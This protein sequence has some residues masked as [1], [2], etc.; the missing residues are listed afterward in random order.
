[1]DR[2]ETEAARDELLEDNEDDLEYHI[3]FP[4]PAQIETT[5]GESKEF[6]F[7]DGGRSGFADTEPVVFLLGWM[8]C[9]DKHLAKY[10]KIYE[11]AG[12]VTIRYTA[13]DEYILFH[14]DKIRPLAKKLL[15]LVEEMSLENSP[16]FC[17]AFSNGGCSVYQYMVES[18]HNCPE[19][20]SVRRNFR[21]QVFD[22]GPGRARVGSLVRAMAEVVPGGFSDYYVIKYAVAIAALLYVVLLRLIRRFAGLAAG[23]GSSEEAS[24]SSSSGAEG[25]SASNKF[26]FDYLAKDES[27]GSVPYLFLYS[28]ADEIVLASDVDE[29]ADG[30]IES[31]CDVTKVCY[32]DSKHVGHLL[33]HRESYITA[34]NAFVVKCLKSLPD[35]APEPKKSAAATEEGDKKKSEEETE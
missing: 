26:C 5:G 4:S 32:E 25:S 22:S 20:E 12:C 2:D 16:V 28:S 34:V 13:P 29:F 6:V 7:V 3:T 24:S 11:D 18:M 14:Q 30:K 9:R 21:G 35:E 15:D 8:G 19:Y 31:G 10:S 17:H 33:A 1:M 23:G 27:L